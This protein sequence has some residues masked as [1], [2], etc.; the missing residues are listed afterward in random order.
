[1]EEADLRQFEA[2]N[3]SASRAYYEADRASVALGPSVNFINNLSLAAI[4]VF[5]ALLYLQGGLP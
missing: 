3:E 5:G 4:S 1:M 2:F